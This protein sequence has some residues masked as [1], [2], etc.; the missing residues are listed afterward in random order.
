MECFWSPVRL[1]FPGT[2]FPLCGR[3]HHCF[4]WEPSEGALAATSRCEAVSSRGKIKSFSLL[5]PSPPISIT[6][7]HLMPL[8]SSVVHPQWCS[9]NMHVTCLLLFLSCVVWFLPLHST[10]CYGTIYFLILREFCYGAESST[11]SWVCH[12]DVCRLKAK[13]ASPLR[14]PTLCF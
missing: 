14:D 9:L 10:W 12:Q 5:N 6:S 2:K 4:Y 3:T 8:A 13:Q 1:T 7:G 11:H